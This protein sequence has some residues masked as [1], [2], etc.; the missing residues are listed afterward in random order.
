MLKELEPYSDYFSDSY[1]PYRSLKFITI[2]TMRYCQSECSFKSDKN[3]LLT[4]PMRAGLLRNDLC[5]LSN[6]FNRVYIP[7]RRQIAQE[8]RTG[9]EM[10]RCIGLLQNSKKNTCEINKCMCGECLDCITYGYG[11]NGSKASKV[12]ADEAFSLH[13]YEIISQETTNIAVYETRTIYN[14]D[15]DAY[16]QSLF[17]LETVKPG[18]IFLDMETLVNVS[19]QQLL[20]ILGNIIRT[21]RYGAITSKIGKMNNNILSIAFSNAE[22]FSNME[23][24]QKTYDIACETLKV[25][26]K[27][28]LP[29][30]SSISDITNS[31][32]TALSALSKDLLCHIDFIKIKE[33]EQLNQSLKSL[34]SDNKN[35]LKYFSNK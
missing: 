21:K 22:L 16:S 31:A 6:A 33:M 27:E 1:D 12:I 34:Y 32:K 18:A 4:T 8:R 10:L 30:P 29:F 7:K 2:F 24:T 28:L 35:L 13:P 3:K 25:P 17:S 9:R 23:W 26:Q 19:E 11:L 5:S 14:T 20:Y 15:D